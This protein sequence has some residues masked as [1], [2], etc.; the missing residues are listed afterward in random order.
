MTS[1]AL[2]PVLDGWNGPAMATLVTMDDVSAPVLIW[3]KL[4]RGP[5][6]AREGAAE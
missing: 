4:L 1:L 2:T 3:V 6:S 5:V